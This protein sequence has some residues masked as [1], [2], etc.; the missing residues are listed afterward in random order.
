MSMREIIRALIKESMYE[1][2]FEDAFADEL[3]SGI[4]PEAIFNDPKE[5]HRFAN[6]HIKNDI[7]ELE[8]YM[9][10]EYFPVN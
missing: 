3:L 4:S 7:P 5:A 6:E 9:M 2:Q 1:I 8:G 10:T